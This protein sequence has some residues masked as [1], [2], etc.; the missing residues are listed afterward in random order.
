MYVVIFEVSSITHVAVVVFIFVSAI[1]ICLHCLLSFPSKLKLVHILKCVQYII[2]S[3]F[4][5][6]H[7]KHS[8]FFGT[9]LPFTLSLTFY[10]FNIPNYC[11]SFIHSYAKTFQINFDITPFV[12]VSCHLFISG[13]LFL[14]RH[15]SCCCC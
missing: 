11:N 8:L 5:A 4:N 3:N 12:F 15:L 6:S 10:S 2:L 7:I 9:N 14:Y 13:L 1:A